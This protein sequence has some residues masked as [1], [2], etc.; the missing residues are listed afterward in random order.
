M[1]APQFNSAAEEQTAQAICDNNAQCLLDYAATGNVQ[2]AT[3]TNNNSQAVLST[4]KLFGLLTD[5]RASL[6]QN[7]CSFVQILR[8]QN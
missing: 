3:A 6:S 1:F 8:L 7:K 5:T 2:L 4:S